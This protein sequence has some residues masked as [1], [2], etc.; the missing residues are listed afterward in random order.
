MKVFEKNHHIL[1][2]GPVWDV[3]TQ[4]YYWVDIVEGNIVSVSHTLDDHQTIHLPDKVAC[5]V[6]TETGDLLLALSKQIA[7]LDPKT[8]KLTYLTEPAAIGE[9]EMFNDGKV[10][11]MGRF[12]IGT[13][14]IEHAAPDGKLYTFEGGA[15]TTKAEGFTISNGL[16]WNLDHSVM[17]FTDSPVKTIYQYDFDK[18]SGQ[19][20]NP[21]EFAKIDRGVP[22]GLTV[23]SLGQVWSAHWNGHCVTGYSPDGN[24][25]DVIEMP[26]E[27]PTSCAFGGPDLKTMF[28]TSATYYESP[29]EDTQN[30]YVFF[31]EM[32]VPG[33]PSYLA[34]L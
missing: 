8:Q 1:G 25:I 4:R 30:G 6:L 2:E 12:W 31:K 14:H 18:D 21:K 17:Y 19:I 28:I 23:D 5:V 16:D 34:K 7:T 3:A 27:K 26:C 32:R 9:H 33:R 11:C 20:S 22:D 13:K 29:A 10:D 24:I 15:L